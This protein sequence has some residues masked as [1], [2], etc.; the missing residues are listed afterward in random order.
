MVFAF[1]EAGVCTPPSLL[2]ARFVV[3][4][5]CRACALCVATVAEIPRYFGGD[6]LGQPV[7]L[8][9]ASFLAVGARRRPAPLDAASHI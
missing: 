5:T 9:T 3:L 8:A 6:H 1:R 2:P 4:Y 7:G